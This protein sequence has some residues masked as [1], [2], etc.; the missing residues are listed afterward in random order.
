MQNLF[1]KLH[2][3]SHNY[4]NEKLKKEDLLIIDSIM[5]NLLRNQNRYAKNVLGL[6]FWYCLQSARVSSFESNIKISQHVK[7]S[8]SGTFWQFYALQ[9]NHKRQFQV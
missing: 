7:D 8:S 6:Q 9:N 5:K 1:Y 3:A 4:K 2:H